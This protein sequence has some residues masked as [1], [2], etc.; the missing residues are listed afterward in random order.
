MG[1]SC[2]LLGADHLIFEGGRLQD[3]EKKASYNILNSKQNYMLDELNIMHRFST[4]KISAPVIQWGI[5]NCKIIA[6]KKLFVIT[7]T[8]QILIP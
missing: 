4:R 6:L 8:E 7:S 5:R 1:L 3:F 2:L